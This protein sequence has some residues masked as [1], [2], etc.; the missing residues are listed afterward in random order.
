MQSLQNIEYP[1]VRFRGQVTE[2]DGYLEQK[3][4]NLMAAIQ[5]YERGV[6]SLTLI[7]NETFN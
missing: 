7:G 2:P 6:C 4:S 5:L 3:V 1:L